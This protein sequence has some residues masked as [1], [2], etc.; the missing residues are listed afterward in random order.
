MTEV[1]SICKGTGI[2][3]TPHGRQKWDKETK[4]VIYFVEYTYHRCLCTISSVERHD[5]LNNEKS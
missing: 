2:T 5:I 1:C 4:Q 3:R